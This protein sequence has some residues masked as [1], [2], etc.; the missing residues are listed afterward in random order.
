MGLWPLRIVITLLCA[1]VIDGATTHRRFGNYSTTDSLA[2]IRCQVKC[3]DKPPNMCNLEAC[4]EELRATAKLGICPSIPT[5]HEHLFACRDVCHGSDWRCS[6]VQKCCRHSCGT[7]CIR[8]TGVDRNPLLPPMPYNLQLHEKRPG[9]RT[10]EMSWEIKLHINRT[11]PMVFLVEGRSHLGAFFSEQ[12][13]GPWNA[14]AVQ[15]V[16]EIKYREV[17]VEKKKHVGNVKLRPGRWYQ[18]RVAAVNENGTRGYSTYTKPFQLTEN[19]RLIPPPQNLTFGPMQ[20][21]GNS[22]I[23]TVASWRAPESEKPITKYKVSWF[24]RGRRKLLPISQSTVPQ[25]VNSMELGNLQPNSVYCVQVQA[26]SGIGKNRLKSRRE[27]KL[28]NTTIPGSF[29][30][31]ALDSPPSLVTTSGWTVFQDGIAGKLDHRHGVR[32]GGHS[33]TMRYLATKPGEMTVKASWSGSPHESYA[34]DLCRGKHCLDNP[35]SG[36]YRSEKTHSNSFE[37]FNLRFATLYS[38]RL[39]VTNH[40]LA[41][42]HNFVRTFSTPLCENFRKKHSLAIKC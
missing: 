1:I 34:I 20:I 35:T 17:K 42:H 29:V 16:Y 6:D 37:F 18:F 28:L 30:L 15:P 41:K 23:F 11:A 25:S 8:P 9:V 13:L 19:V 26:I 32:H 4:M 40:A 31:A 2:M 10:V 36:D 39:R 5:E 22:T 27:T 21:A 24:I 38:I 33:I 14:F 7:L 12:K 3:L